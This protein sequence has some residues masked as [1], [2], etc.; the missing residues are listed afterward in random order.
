MVNK[1]KSNLDMKEG[2]DIIELDFGWTPNI[3][4][5]GYL[6][7]YEGIQSEILNSTRFEKNSDLNT[8]Y[9]GK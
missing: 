1:C 3:L 4:K 5:E 7:V 8:T 9:L 6:D 2:R